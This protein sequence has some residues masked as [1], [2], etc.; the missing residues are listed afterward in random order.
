V[1]AGQG[2]TLDGVLGLPKRAEVVVAQPFV[3]EIYRGGSRQTLQFD[4]DQVIKEV[5]TGP[6]PPA[7]GPVAQPVG[8]VVPPVKTS[9]IPPDVNQLK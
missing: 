4:R 8:Q 2:L 7:T 5:Y 9:E 1:D 3:T 6:A